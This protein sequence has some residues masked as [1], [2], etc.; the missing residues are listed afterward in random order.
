VAFGVLGSVGNVPDE[1]ESASVAP[2]HSEVD[3]GPSATPSAGPGGFESL[4]RG[5]SAQGPGAASP[6]DLATLAA[7]QRSAGNAAVLRLLRSVAPPPVDDSRRRIAREPA[8]AAPG[9][10]L[11]VPDEGTPPGP[12]QMALTPFLDQVEQS[13]KAIAERELSASIYRVAGCPWIEHWLGYYR[14]RSPDE[15]DA[16]VRRYAPDAGSARTIEDYLRLIT[17]RVTEGIVGWQATGQLP[18]GL[19]AGGAGAAPGAAE[20]AAAAAASPPVAAG[21]PEQ[22]VARAPAST[23][24]PL[25]PAAQARMGSAFGTDFSD[26]RVHAGPAGQA[27]ASREHARAVTIG[28]DIS[29]A[30]GRYAPGTPAGDALLAHELAHVQQQTDGPTVAR[31]E[32]AGLEADAD[33]AALDALTELYLP[34]GGRRAASAQRTGPAIQRCGD[35]IEVPEQAPPRAYPEIVKE[36]QGLKGRKEA[37]LAGKEPD[38]NLPEINKRIEEIGAELQR[39]GVKLETAEIMERLSVDPTTDL[40]QVRGQIVRMPPGEPHHGDKLEF[41]A[42]LDYVPPGRLVKYAWRWRGKNREY[43]FGDTGRRSSK[44]HVDIGT[45]FWYG[46]QDV[47]AGGGM[48][49]KCY[50][51]LGD[52]DKEATPAPLST[53]WMDLKKPHVEDFSLK[54]SQKVTIT[55][56]PVIFEPAIWAPTPDKHWLDWDINGT[57]VAENHFVLNYKFGKPG[58]YKVTATLYGKG[59][60]I[61]SSRGKRID[62]KSIDIVVQDPDKAGEQMLGQMSGEQAPPS[63]KRLEAT[64]ES[65]IKEIEGRVADGGEQRDFWVER[66]KA[67]RKR[68]AKL[69]ENIPDLASSDV[70][71][72]D[73]SSVEAGHA[74][75][76]PVKAVLILPSGG[77]PQPLN[78][79]VRA[80]QDAGKWRARI[81]DMTSSDVYA[82][83]GSGTAAVDAYA[84]AFREWI[85]DHPYPRGGKVKYEFNPPGWSVPTTFKCRDTAWETVKAWVDGILTVG[86]IIVGGLL[87]LTPEPTGATK[88]LGYLFISASV[89]RSAIAIYENLELGIDALDSRNVIEGLSILTSALGV[90]GSLMRQYGVRAVSPLIYRVG[91]W[92]VMASLAGDVGTMA[93]VSKEALASL[94]AIQGD[95]TKDDGE[96]NAEFLRVSASLFASGA[97]FFVTNKDLLKQGLKPSDFFKV[98]PKVAAAGGGAQPSLTTGSRLDLGL[99]L[100][101]AGDLHTAERLGAGKIGDAELLDRHASLPWLKSGAPADVGEVAKRLSPAAL[102]SVKDA[103]VAEVRKALDKVADDK[104]FGNLA[105]HYKSGAK[106]RDLAAGMAKIEQALAG[107]PERIAS[108]KRTAALQAKGGMDGFDK[109]VDQAQSRLPA[110]G[111]PTPEHIKG[112]TELTGELDAMEALAKEA[113][114][115]NKMLVFTPAPQMPPGVPTPRSFDITIYDKTEKIAPGGART[116]ERLIEVHTETK[117][118]GQS[119]HLHTGVA[120]AASKLPLDRPKPVKGGPKTA[121]ITP[122]ATLPTA[123]KEAAVVLTKWPPAK[124][125]SKT[126]NADGSYEL[127]HGGGTKN[128][129]IADDL[130]RELNGPTLDSVGA[131]YLD[132]VTIVDGKSGRKIFSLVNEPA[133]PTVPPAAPGDGGRKRWKRE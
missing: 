17:E 61:L 15:V 109:W 112:T 56:V 39:M 75:T 42:R 45:G 115:P 125:A 30:A 98:N 128:G 54:S 32:D 49:V 72:D 5:V 38:S 43:E 129:H 44:D 131:Q 41:H 127:I 58:S 106:M 107:Q 78:I 1:R 64:L 26:V 73:P 57:K 12:G 130:V 79:H 25:D 53:G 77:G 99:E 23:G 84:A 8:P 35:D 36:L 120:H 67:Q 22:G 3:R 103:S 113:T 50:V 85:D 83:E 92:T 7:L 62:A 91:N 76:G 89:A 116:P 132:R 101:K 104:L 94:R 133:V 9:G 87:L 2:T 29:F 46:Q 70:L 80:W 19:A 6:Q 123:S 86:G 63:T 68:L 97:M 96:K 110:T 51:Y 65:S 31:L 82:R 4:L 24:R 71:P 55:D 122:G 117:E 118:V 100:K 124:T 81:V 28:R 108:M 47:T 52:D 102:N 20:G 60:T 114:D 18:D 105:E 126:V 21:A 27:L 13:V 95:P 37:V 69:R 14:Q 40:L 59:D 16:A 74:Y 34:G 48:E 66:L 11:L 121:T 111:A 90:S 33:L 119:I 10:A 88:A 93:F